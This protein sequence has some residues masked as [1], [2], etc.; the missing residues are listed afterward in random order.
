MFAQH[1]EEMLICHCSLLCSCTPGIYQKQN[2]VI[3]RYTW[4]MKFAHN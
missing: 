4:S 2:S 3:D 1:H